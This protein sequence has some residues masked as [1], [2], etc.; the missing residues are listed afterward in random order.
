[1][2]YSRRSVLGAAAAGAAGAVVGPPLLGAAPAT[3][4]A[5]AR[6]RFPGH[7]PGRVYVGLTGGGFDI[8]SSL[9]APVGMRRTY[10]KWGDLDREMRQI[11]QD[12]AARR[13]PWISFKPPGR[14]AT[15]WPE[16]AQGRH[17]QD[18]RRRARKYARLSKPVVVTFNHE[19]H[20]D[21]GNPDAFK[22]AWVRIH[23]VMKD[24][25][26]LKNVISAPIVGEW[27]FNPY[28]RHD[29]PRNYLGKRVLRRCDLVGVDLYQ[30]ASGD[31]YDVRLRRV[32]RWLSRH[33]HPNMMVGLGESGATDDFGTPSGSRWWR[34][35]W[36][37]ARQCDRLFG[38]N[39][40]NN[41]LKHH[42]S[43][44]QSSAKKA[45]FNRSVTDSVAT[46]LKV[47]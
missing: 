2:S 5:A 25:T 24:E 12:H 35:C 29:R 10:Y 19:P 41:N 27:V 15:A 3:A 44:S 38:V 14:A 43:L 1:M 28:N 22:R 7:V 8:A 23:D 42:W 45:A 31:G 4:Q 40:W 30:N 16:I 21:N 13:M 26:G 33:G 6:V 47:L 46:R 34:D 20:N 18:I 9:D 39:Y 37:Y 32:L 36:D 11:A 17:D